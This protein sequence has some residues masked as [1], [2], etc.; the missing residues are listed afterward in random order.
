MTIPI[1]QLLDSIKSQSENLNAQSKVLHSL[2]DTIISQRKEFGNVK[3]DM[4]DLK[5]SFAQNLSGISEIKKYLDSMRRGTGING[6]QI[7]P[8]SGAGGASPDKGFFTN[9]FTKMFG[10]SKYQQNLL[11]EISALKDITDLQSK[12]IRFIKNQYSE[13]TKAYDREMLATAIANKLGNLSGGGGRSMLG[14]LAAGAGSLLGGA[15]SGLGSMI[16]GALIGLGP[17]FAAAITALGGVLKAAIVALGEAIIAGLAGLFGK[18]IPTPGSPG[19]GGRAPGGGPII[20]SPGGG[21]PQLPGPNNPQLPGP[22]NPQIPGNGKPPFKPKGYNNQNLDIT[23][24]T[25]NGSKGRLSGGLK[26]AAWIAALLFGVDILTQAA[27]NPDKSFGEILKDVGSG[28]LSSLNPFEGFKGPAGSVDDYLERKQKE[29]D[30]AAGVTNEDDK[31]FRDEMIA[32]AKKSSEKL[33]ENE[34]EVDKLVAGLK[35]DLDGWQDKFKGMMAE[36]LQGFLTLEDKLEDFIEEIALQGYKKSVEP[37]LNDIGFNV[38]VPDAQGKMTPTRI[39][40]APTFGTSLGEAL[41]E[42]YQQSKELMDPAK[43]A[44]ANYATN[45]INNINN[46]NKS[47]DVLPAPSAPVYGPGSGALLRYF[48]TP[49]QSK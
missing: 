33:K 26:G 13:K 34:S 45:I 47:A 42:T 7:G 17:V 29:K 30:K 22:N 6:T 41:N 49:N 38:D 21:K 10:P 5:K 39:N 9:L 44:M 20:V 14:G 25:P 12:D 23:D 37:K 3:K 31:K 15:L 1:N 19:G 32:G 8:K 46:N 11:N 27:Q 28:F 43:Q 48:E 16:G 24:V 40:L 2:S 4:G 18:N 36:G 35:K